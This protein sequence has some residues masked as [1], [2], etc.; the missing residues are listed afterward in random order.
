M[1]T[2]HYKLNASNSDWLCLCLVVLFIE[3]SSC[4]LLKYRKRTADEIC[5]HMI[6][7]VA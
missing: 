2:L 4:R 7:A 3:V 5:E 6:I 1:V